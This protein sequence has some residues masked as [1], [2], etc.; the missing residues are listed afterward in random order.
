MHTLYYQCST[1][2]LYICTIYWVAHTR[3]H[4]QHTHTHT[5]THTL[6][7]G[8]DFLGH[9]PGLKNCC[10]VAMEAVSWVMEKISGVDTRSEAVKIL[11]VPTIYVAGYFRGRKSLRILRI[12]QLHEKSE[13]FYSLCI[14]AKR[15]I[16]CAV[17]ENKHCGDPTKTFPRN[18]LGQLI[19]KYLL[20]EN[21]GYTVSHVAPMSN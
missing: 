6:R 21:N 20:L 7:E 14:I 4:P 19:G 2:I 5:H 8:I 18:S 12:L 3:T 17:F 1:C 10:F 11:Q 15:N 13:R 9:L 16:A